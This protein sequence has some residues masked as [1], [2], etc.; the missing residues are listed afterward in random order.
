MPIDKD[1]PPEVMTSA[2]EIW[3]NPKIADSEK[4]VLIQSLYGPCVPTTQPTPMVVTFAT[5]NPTPPDK[6]LLGPGPQLGAPV[7]L[8]QKSLSNEDKEALRAV[9]NLWI[10]GR[11]SRE[12]TQD[13]INRIIDQS[14]R[15]L[16]G[17]LGGC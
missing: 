14:T 1:V 13:R 2:K 6:A 5:T 8:L 16:Y 9:L 7:W 15:R 17:P 3:R 12:Q 10:D 4:T 11:L